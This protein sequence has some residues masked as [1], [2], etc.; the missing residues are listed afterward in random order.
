MTK[1]KV[2]RNERETYKLISGSELWT[3]INPTYAQLLKVFG[4]PTGNGD[5]YKTDAEWIIQL[6]DGTVFSIYNYKTGKNYLGSSGQ[7]LSEI[8][9]WHVG[10]HKGV[11]FA[12]VKVGAF[13][14]EKGLMY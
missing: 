2:L 13:L 5:G 3:Y 9:D 8:R 10:L 11:P 4:K 14:R 12:S 1:F 6:D 7:N